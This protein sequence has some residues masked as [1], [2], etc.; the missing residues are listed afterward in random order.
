MAE[1]AR[2][3]IYDALRFILVTGDEEPVQAVDLNRGIR[4]LNRMM[5]A[6]EAEGIDLSYVAVTAGTDE[7]DVDDGAYE[8]IIANLALRMWP[9]YYKGDPNQIVVLHAAKGKKDLY[10]IAV[11]VEE[12]DFPDSLPIGSGNENQ[13]GIY[14]DPFFEQEYPV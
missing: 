4:L 5:A 12:M 10:M 6:F 7:V 2:E 14:D 1:T 9:Y 13:A 11:E 3:I 8:G